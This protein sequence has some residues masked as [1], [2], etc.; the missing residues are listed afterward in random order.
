M[1]APFKRMFAGIVKAFLLGTDVNAILSELFGLQI[2]VAK[3]DRIQELIQPKEL[4][5]ET[6]ADHGFSSDFIAN[7]WDEFLHLGLTISKIFM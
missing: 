3:N 6:M 1:L 4:E 7:S 5:S 2:R